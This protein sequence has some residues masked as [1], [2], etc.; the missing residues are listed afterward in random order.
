MSGPVLLRQTEQQ[1]PA[2]AA[3]ASGSALQPGSRETNQTNAARRPEG[4]TLT[5]QREQVSHLEINVPRPPSL[6]RA[7]PCHL[8]PRSSI[9]TVHLARADACS[10]RLRFGKSLRSPWG[11][12]DAGC[13]FE[14]VYK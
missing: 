13:D 6:F 9:L 8:P 12:P 7:F 10:P 1:R 14:L 2:G 3:L 4:V 5:P 11:P